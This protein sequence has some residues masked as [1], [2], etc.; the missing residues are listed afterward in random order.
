MSQH[1]LRFISG[2]DTGR[3]YLLAPDRHIMIGR[4]SG[5]DLLLVDNKVSRQHAAITTHAGEVMLHDLESR[6]G[7]FVNDRRITTAMLKVGDEIVL[8]SSRM[9]LETATDAAVLDGQ[10]TVKS[11]APFED[12]KLMKRPEILMEGDIARIALPDLIQM[13][14]SAAKTG[15]LVV[16]SDEGVG[17]IHFRAGQVRHATL[18][19][20]P[21]MPARKVFCRVIRWTQG[22]F[23]LQA[24]KDGEPLPSSD[25]IAEST[26]TLLFDALRQLDE[27]ILLEPQL[28]RPDARLTVST[29]VADRLQDL[30][31]D[32]I[33]VYQLA[34]LHL[35][36][37]AVVDQYPGCDLEACT[38]LLRLLRAGLIAVVPRD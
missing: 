10:V 6:N 33:Q 37:Q 30:S 2:K 31:T 22:K 23:E 11:G 4:D 9:R 7:T 3:E 13:L 5:V 14:S 32:E 34:A 18:D 8:G 16:T 26:T 28:P 21:Q 1:V 27:T 19:H 35:S 25:E 15:L 24:A 36:V 38:C 17:R 12:S 20:H 29:P